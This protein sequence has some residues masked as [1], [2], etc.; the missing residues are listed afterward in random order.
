MVKTILESL[1]ANDLSQIEEMVTLHVEEL[2]YK[3]VI[4][5]LSEH[6]A[7]SKATSLIHITKDELIIMKALAIVKS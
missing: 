4:L 3:T 1:M 6:L 5:L 7:W 2:S